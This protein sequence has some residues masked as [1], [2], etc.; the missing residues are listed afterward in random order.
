M[1]D[2]W[3][4]KGQRFEIGILGNDCRGLFIHT[5]V[6][7]FSTDIQNIIFIKAHI[8]ELQIILASNL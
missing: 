5:H 3:P 4:F 2:S 6:A 1:P 8:R 7:L